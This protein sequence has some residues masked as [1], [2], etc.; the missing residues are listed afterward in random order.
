MG[1]AIIVVLIVM[2]FGAL[3]VSAATSLARSPA[4][5]RQERVGV[6]ARLMC[7]RA[8][9]YTAVRIAPSHEDRAPVVTWCER[10]PAGRLE[11]GRECFTVLQGADPAIA[12]T[13]PV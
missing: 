13:E 6:L 9:Q 11:C 8:E 4:G 10:F 2:A 1:T 5:D 7:P 3:V 12:V